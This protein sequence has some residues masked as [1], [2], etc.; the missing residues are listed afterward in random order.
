MQG[1]G[2]G[3][4]RILRHGKGGGVLLEPFLEQDEVLPTQKNHPK[5]PANLEKGSQSTY[6]AALPSPMRRL[7]G[8]SALPF[9]WAMDKTRFTG[10]TKAVRVH[11]AQERRIARLKIRAWEQQTQAWVIATF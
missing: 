5:G 2:L 6:P 9:T 8:Q 3:T 1:G 10:H 11:R 4:Y 7:L